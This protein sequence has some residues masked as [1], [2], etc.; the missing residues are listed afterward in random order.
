M[1]GLQ[2]AALPLAARRWLRHGCARLA[3]LTG[4]LGGTSEMLV[5]APNQK[6]ARDRQ[7]GAVVTE[8]LGRLGVVVTVGAASPSR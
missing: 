6:L 8:P 4:T 5:L 2:G 7:A 3:A 1:R